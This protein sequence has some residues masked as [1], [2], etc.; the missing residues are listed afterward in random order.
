MP[1]LYGPNGKRLPSKA[2]AARREVF[3]LRKEINTMRAK[4][5]AAQ[6]VTS[7]EHHWSNADTLD[8][9]AANSPDVR[10]KLRARSRYEIIENNPYL[11]GRYY[12]L[13]MIL[14]GAA[15]TLRSKTPV[16]PVDT[17]APLKLRCWNGW[18]RFL[19][20]KKSGV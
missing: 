4:Y 14:Q 6:T 16:S 8:P 18:K 12:Q 2:D 9:H 19:F 10:R 5:D 15:R 7:N 13:R 11:K 20:V 3:R 17:V 1:R